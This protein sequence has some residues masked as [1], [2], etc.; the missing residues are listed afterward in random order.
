M[1]K[2]RYAKHGARGEA[3]AQPTPEDGEQSPHTVKTGHE[4]GGFWRVVQRFAQIGGT[5]FL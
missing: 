3:V 2:N 1:Q 4:S 5:P